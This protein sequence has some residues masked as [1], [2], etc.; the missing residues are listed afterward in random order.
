MAQT[1]YVSVGPLTAGSATVYAASQAPTS[2]TGLTL[3]GT[4]SATPRRALLTFGNDAVTTRTLV[5]SG[6]GW[7]GY[8]LSETLAIPSGAGTIQSALDYSSIT[9]AIPRGVGWSANVS[10]G[11]NG[12]ASSDWVSCDPWNSAALSL[13]VDA[14][15]TVNYTVE[16]TL[17]DPNDL[18]SGPGLAGLVWQPN[19]AMQ[20]LPN[21]LQST[22]AFIPKLVRCTLNS[23]SGSCNFTVNQIGANLPTLIPVG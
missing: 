11:T 9:S 3:T 23:G 5:L 2:G 21:S 1:H 6:I 22:G 10:L 18:V 8:P 12:V 19:T 13:Q 4:V 14:T 16:W 20:A 17:E 15:G 7:T